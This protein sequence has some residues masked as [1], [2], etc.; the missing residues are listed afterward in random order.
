MLTKENL[1]SMDENDYMNE[2]Q[3]CFFKSI[4]TQARVDAADSIALLKKDFTKNENNSDLNDQGTAQEMQQQNLLTV[5]RKG[6]ESS[7][8]NLALALIKSCDY[9]YCQATGDEI[10]LGRL[11]ANPTTTLSVHAKE[12]QEF[13]MKTRGVAAF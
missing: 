13:L 8:I 1:L 7:E 6:R 10:G 11:L 3:L 9:G 4:L 12:R 2:A 5:S